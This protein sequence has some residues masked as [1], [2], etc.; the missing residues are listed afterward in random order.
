MNAH[1]KIASPTGSTTLHVD[2]ADLRNALAFTSRAIER[3]NT[4]PILGQHLFVVTDGALEIH[5]TNLD[6]HAIQRVECKAQGSWSF[7]IGGW[8]L[9]KLISGMTGAVSF[10]INAAKET[11]TFQAAGITLTL[12]TIFPAAEWPALKL[13][14]PNKTAIFGEATL[15]QALRYVTPCISTEVTRYYL[16]GV[17]WPAGKPGEQCRF[18]ST[19]GHRLARYDFDGPSAPRNIIIPRAAVSYMQGMTV[20]GGNGEIQL[21]PR[22]N[23][24]LSITKGD[25]TLHVKEIEGTYPDYTRVIPKDGGVVDVVVGKEAAQRLCSVFSAGMAPHCKI[26]PSLGVIT[27]HLDDGDISIPLGTTKPDTPDEGD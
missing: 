9:R 14:A 15:H 16:N 21:T 27:A 25:Q 17:F 26:S 7:V 11:L 5:A 10:T 6:L 18:V 19:D 24:V 2:V 1:A 23:K 3:R 22:K 12:K 20:K 13:G 4:I 8:R